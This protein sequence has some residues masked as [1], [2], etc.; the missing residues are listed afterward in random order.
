MFFI[1][2]MSSFSQSLELYCIDNWEGGQEHT[3]SGSHV[4]EM[5]LVEEKFQKNISVALSKTSNKCKVITLKHDS[6]TGLSKLIHKGLSNY[7]DLIYIDGSHDAVN[8]L[9]DAIL[10]FKLVRKGG[11]IVFDDYLWG[12]WGDRNNSKNCIHRCPKLAI[13]A[14]VNIY[15]EKIQVDPR[16][17]INQLVALKLC[18]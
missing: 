13:D 15:F 5:N 17:R 18:D 6:F 12:T 14:F 3:T 9:E 1:E 2:S 11:L 8:V 16:V 10:S 4:C 7:F